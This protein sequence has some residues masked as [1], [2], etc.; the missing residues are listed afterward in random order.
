MN[1]QDA[2]ALH[3]VSQVFSTLSLFSA[4]SVE[5]MKRNERF[6]LSLYCE[7]NEQRGY[8]TALSGFVQGTLNKWCSFLAIKH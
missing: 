8:T 4:C 1:L 7:L 3:E 6:H 5:E 2:K